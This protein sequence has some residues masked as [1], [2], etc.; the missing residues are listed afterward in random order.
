MTDLICELSSPKT[1]ANVD[2]LLP[3][4]GGAYTVTNLAENLAHVRSDNIIYIVVV[5]GLDTQ[6]A[7]PPSAGNTRPLSVEP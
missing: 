1:A 3:R 7:V 5:V 6:A 4:N 2:I